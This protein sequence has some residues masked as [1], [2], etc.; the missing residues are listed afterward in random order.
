M[1]LAVLAEPADD[2]LALRK[3]LPHEVLDVGGGE[4]HERAPLRY[5]VLGEALELAPAGRVLIRPHSGGVV[6][7]LVRARARAR[8]RAGVGLGLG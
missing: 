3:G 5:D 4:E 7:R 2:A 6:A 1:L 8:A